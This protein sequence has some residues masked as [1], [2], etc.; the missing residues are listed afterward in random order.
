MAKTFYEVV[1][2]GNYNFVYGMLEGY[3]LATGKSFIYY[4]SKKVNVKAITF[5]EVIKELLTLTTRLQHIIIESK[6]WKKFEAAVKK[7]QEG[8]IINK[9][10]IKSVKKI[11]SASFEFTF[12]CY[13]KK[14]GDEIKNLLKS[15]PKTVTLVDYIPKEEV[16]KDV[17]GT[18]M[19][20]PDHE[21]IF[22]GKGRLVGDIETII[23][24]NKTFDEHPL[25]DVSPIYLQL[26]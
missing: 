1:L 15:L 4:L 16:H 23:A 5:T 19:Y 11:E 25:I 9:R 7:Q 17:K 10:Y 3:K 20:A 26:K 22:K 12:E 2:E 14:Y 6:S 8:S 21:Y 18:V 24:L 13:A